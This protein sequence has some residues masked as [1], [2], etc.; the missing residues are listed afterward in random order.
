MATTV[1]SPVW[2]RRP[3]VAPLLFVCVVFLALSLPPYLAFDPARSRV[4]ATFALHYPLLVAHVLFGSVALLTCCLQIWPWLRTRHPRFHR[5]TGRVYVLGGVLPAGLLGLTIGARSSF[6]PLV[7]VSDVLLATLWLACTFA[8]LRAARRRRFAEH[9]TWMIR[10][11]ALTTSIMMNRVW[12]V[13]AAIVLVP[14]LSTTFGNSEAHLI[15]T[16]AALAAWL[17]WTL[18]L[19]AAQWWLD[20]TAAPRAP[21]REIVPLFSGAA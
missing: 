4:P 6:G 18:N 19:L 16:I 20:R 11:F 13:V 2:W 9:R 7:R 1:G 15:Q 8:G 3:W 12:A 10:S 14:Q 17:G 21:V 5:I